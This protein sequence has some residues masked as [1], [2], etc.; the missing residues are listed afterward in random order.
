[1]HDDDV[2]ERDFRDWYDEL[3]VGIESAEIDSR[4]GLSEDEHLAEALEFY[5]NALSE[6]R[7]R[8]AEPPAHVLKIAAEARDEGDWDT[9]L[10]AAQRIETFVRFTRF[11]EEE[12]E[13]RRR[14]AERLRRRARKLQRRSGKSY[15][16]ARRE[17]LAEIGRPPAT[18]RSTPRSRPRDRRQRT[19]RRAR[20]PTRQCDDDLDPDDDL[21]RHLLKWVRR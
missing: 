21:L 8:G 2:V 3:I 16:D 12:A 1:M 19:P 9:L 6:A 7:A 15:V 17:V 13:R 18:P 5:E 20:A 14:F 4:L 10:W 11:G